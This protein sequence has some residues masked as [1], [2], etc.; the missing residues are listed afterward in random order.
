MFR[1]AFFRGIRSIPDKLR[2]SCLTVPVNFETESFQINHT[3]L[4]QLLAQIVL[5]N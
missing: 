3:H 1:D 2:V 5:D 4:K